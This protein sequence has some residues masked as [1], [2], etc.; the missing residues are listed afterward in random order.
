[1]SRSFLLLL[2]PALLLGACREPD[3]PTAPVIGAGLVVDSDPRG[4]QILLDGAP[5]QRMTPDSFFDLTTEPHLLQLRLD[6]AGLTY[7]AGGTILPTTDRVLRVLV[8]LLLECGAPPCSTAYHSPGNVGFAVSATGPL[9][10]LEG[11]GAGAVWPLASGNS[12][13]SGA[14]P[15]VAGVSVGAGDTVALGPYDYAYTAG[16]PAPELHEGAFRLTQSA[17]IIPPGDVRQTVRP[18]VRGLQ[19]EEEILAGGPAPGSVVVRVTFRNITDQPAYQTLDPLAIGGITYRDVWVGMAVDADVGASEDDLVTY[20]PDLD[21]A[22]TFDRD[23]RES[24]FSTDWRERPGLVGLRVLE[25]PAGT[26]VRLNAWPRDLD[27][28]AEGLRA[29]SANRGQPER[30]GWRWLSATQTVLPDHPSAQIGHAPTAAADYRMSAA[31][32][33][34]T[35]APGEA[36]T[37]TLAVVF[38]A[39]EPGTFTGGTAVPAGDPTDASRDIYRIGAGLRAEAVAAEGLLGEP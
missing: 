13:V 19:V 33:P 20:F 9:L 37:V 16:R 28:Q 38:A 23:F 5:T 34:L 36:A 22:V 4:A 10:Y 31:A 14:M 1:M 17:W 24:G 39:P 8:P 18:T 11:Q 25:R 7:R 29:I 35:L 30:S 21:M 32:G 12:Y 15:V 6:S 3:R 27:W 2:A 26:S